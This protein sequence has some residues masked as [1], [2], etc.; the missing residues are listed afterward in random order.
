VTGALLPI[1][2]MLHRPLPVAWDGVP[3][4]WRPWRP[5]HQVFICDRSRRK[6]A[7]AE[8]CTSC[9][10]LW[11]PMSAVGIVDGIAALTANRCTSCGS[12]VV[13]DQ[14]GDVWDLD[15]TDY[16]PTGSVAE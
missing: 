12:D 2:P 4:D 7:P 9:G 5:W 10:Q 14:L 6:P 1:D 16:G 3:V 8:R 13:T 11:R 15:E